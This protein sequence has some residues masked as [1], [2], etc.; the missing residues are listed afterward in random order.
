[1]YITR[2]ALEINGASV[3]DFKAVT[4]KSRVQAKQ[5][6]LMY[7]SGTSL[8][9]QRY[10]V[11]VDYVVPAVS[12]FNFENLYGG[13]LTLEYDN[14]ERVD[15]GGVAVMSVGDSTIDGE[16]ELVKKIGLICETRNGATGA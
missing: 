11:E 7:K 16:N 15:F 10:Q 1:M 5:V 2:C 9:T 6:N 14:G 3:T 13:T 8:L 12:P 4:E